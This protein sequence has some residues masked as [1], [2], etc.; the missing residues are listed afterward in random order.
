MLP[1][2]SDALIPPVR[3]PS[4]HRDTAGG[5]S[6]SL[7]L[8]VA[9]ASYGTKNEPY[10]LRLINEYQAMA[11]TVELVVL[12]NVCRQLPPG[13]ELVRVDLRNKDPWTLP[14]VHKQLFADRLN[15]CDVFIYSEDDMLIREENVRAFLDVAEAL[16]P[17][18]I[19]G[20]LR[21]EHGADGTFNYPE[22]HGHFHWDTSSVRRRGAYTLAHFTNEH[23]AAYVLTRK[24]LQYAIA[25]HGFLVKPHYGRY[26]LL[27]SAAT[28]P[29]TQCGMTKLLCLSHLEKF[30]IHHL[31]DK[32]AG[33]RFGVDGTELER[34][35]RTLLGLAAREDS[36][37]SLFQTE[38]NLSG[39]RYSK[40]YYE[41]IRPEVV[42]EI[43]ASARTILS[44]GCGWGATERWLAETGKSVVVV[45]LDPIIPRLP[46]DGT[47]ILESNFTK[48]RERLAGR[49]FD[50]ILVL[51]VLHLVPDPREILL[52]LAPLLN[53]GAPIVATVP[54]LL[55]LGMLRSLAR[56]RVHGRQL[57]DYS[58]SGVQ[59]TSRAIV[60]RWF[61]D[62]NLK[63]HNLAAIV[64]S[65]YKT[66]SRWT[67]GWFD[68]LLA[69]EFVI[70]ATHD[71][72]SSKG[73]YG[74]N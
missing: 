73:G 16:P 71:F 43:P 32:Y 59:L 64:T 40:D 68:F 33:T 25:S 14:F 47:E 57:L 69:A 8:L 37:T 70:R 24:H 11:F 67:F 55:S 29:Y 48:A 66:V 21:Y 74:R 4:L 45:P 22:V 41:P 19:P 3:D 60:R 23:A 52:S 72:E 7:K 58:K 17:D 15:D 63:C 62:A 34:Q 28:D 50:C 61:R 6:S 1:T 36:P 54:N 42:R 49:T 51:N 44:V 9:I 10:L 18:E 46:K 31:P 56:R 38:T 26:D 39:G 53:H 5:A 27:C 65:A 13:V 12:S 20:F 35:V 2:R 30:L